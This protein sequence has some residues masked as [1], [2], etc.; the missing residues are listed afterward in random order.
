VGSEV[1]DKSAE[2]LH[3]CFHFESV[4]FGRKPRL[5]AKLVVGNLFEDVG[6]PGH[7]ACTSMK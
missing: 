7:F 2:L 5:G 4:L 1:F 6:D 3:N